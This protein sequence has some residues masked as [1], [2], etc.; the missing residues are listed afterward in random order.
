MAVG[1]ELD[2]DVAVLTVDNPPVN[3]LGHAVRQGLSEGMA[4]AVA[5]A[6]VR[7]VVI[8]GKGGF[9]AGA[10]IREFGQPPREPSLRDLFPPMEASPKPIVAAIAGNALGGG[11]EVALACHYRVATSDAKL[12]LPEVNLGLLPG[13]GGTVR[14][15]RLIGAEAALDIMLSGKPVGA[16]KALELGVVDAL[17]EGDLR[18]EAVAFARARAEEEATH[19]V[20]SRAPGRLAETPQGLFEELR[21]RNAAKWRG[22]VAPQKIVECVE[23]AASQSFDDAYAFERE[24]F[25]ACMES[26]ARKALMHVFFAEREAAKVPG[27]G[28]DVH[29]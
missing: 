24:A 21:R 27:I 25:L 4:R 29:N 26:P 7:A 8:M 3:A 14:L 23:R 12:G 18:A 10:D 22:L 15:P 28:K 1:Y 20:I 13:A 5:D 2:G 6:A 9:I 11:L 16:R 17:V 19:P